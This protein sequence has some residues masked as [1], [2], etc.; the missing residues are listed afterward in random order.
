MSRVLD[1]PRKVTAILRCAVTMEFFDE[2]ADEE[3]VRRCFQQD[4]EDACIVADVS[5]LKE[6]KPVKP[7]NEHGLL[8]DCHV[9]KGDLAKDYRYCPTCGRKLN[10]KRIA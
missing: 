6:R 2:D 10:W 7:V 1:E 4:L 9:C 3:A 5:V 8:Y